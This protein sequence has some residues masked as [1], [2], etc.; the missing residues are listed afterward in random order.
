MHFFPQPVSLFC[1]ELGV[2]HRMHSCLQE[3]RAQAHTSVEHVQKEKIRQQEGP[4][5]SLS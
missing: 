1:E 5:G 3:C 2:E 4:L